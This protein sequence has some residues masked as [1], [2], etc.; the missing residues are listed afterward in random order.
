MG[1]AVDYDHRMSHMNVLV[2]QIITGSQNKFA[3]HTGKKSGKCIFNG[4][5]CLH[6]NAVAIY[7]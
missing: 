3:V 6:K 2:N 1:L 4:Y 7:D 5:F